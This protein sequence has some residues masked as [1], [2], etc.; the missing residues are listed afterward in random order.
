[1]TTS[2]RLRF[3]T[4][5][6]D[7]GAAMLTV[8]MLMAVLTGI[9]STLVMLT[10][11]NL[12][13]A[14]RDRQ[15]TGALATADAGVAQALEYVRHNGVGRLTCM[16]A[17]YENP[18]LAA[19]SPT[20][21]CLT[22]PTGWA[23]P[24]TPQQVNVNGGATCGA[25]S[26]C[27]KVF[28]T[29]IVRYNPPAVKTG[30]YRIHSQGAFGAS[31][32]A[33]A[34]SVDVDVTPTTLPIGVFGK[35]LDGNGGTQLYNVSLFT[36]D[37]VS[38]RYNGSGNGTRFSTGLDPYWGEPAAANSTATV[39]TSNNCGAGGSIHATAPCPSNAELYYDR[40][41][42]GGPVS[43]SSA[44]GSYIGADNQVKTRATTLFTYADLQTYGYRPGG[45]SDKQYDDLR[46]RALSQGLL[47][48]SLSTLAMSLQA[49]VN[50]G[51]ANT[52]VYFDNLTP[53]QTI[54]LKSTHI[55]TAFS[56]TPGNLATCSANS[57]VVV[58][59]TGNLSYQSGTSEWR[60]LALLV[61]E[62]TY[63]GNGG[64]NVLGTLFANN[65]SLG[66]NEN[67]QLDDCFIDNL[68]G[69]LL[70]LDA[71]SFREEDGKDIQ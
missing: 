1:M 65:I 27:Y 46:R 29:S 55:P 20:N 31:A 71:V 24:V 16:D 57:V 30:R 2:S 54:D 50:A 34:V 18:N 28:I 61:P 40:D 23:S 45:L 64:Y 63:K 11:N 59:R 14:S 69:G 35:E 48:P 60:T 26:T 25:A 70:E 53:A 68:P 17:D 47:N 39:S 66:G 51:I 56:R 36:T 62:G 21:P 44:C 4:P 5:S 52:V 32:G 10:T 3:G 6:G 12:E 42:R 49:A 19:T 13:N 22:N 37:C 33:R 8:L 38:P 15:A 9:G 7:T 58:V 41:G 43:P 67:F